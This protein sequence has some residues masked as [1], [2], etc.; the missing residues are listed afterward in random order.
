MSLIQRLEKA[1]A[2]TF[3]MTLQL[4]S[5]FSCLL[6]DNSSLGHIYN[7]NTVVNIIFFHHNNLI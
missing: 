3:H 4:C 1:R 2:T 5:T 7:Q 6:S